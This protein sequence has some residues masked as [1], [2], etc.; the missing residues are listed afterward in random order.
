MEQEY[1]NQ[2]AII[3]WITENLG[4]EVMVPVSGKRVANGFDIY[5]QSFLLPESAIEKEMINDTYNAH[6]L[7]PGVNSYGNWENGDYAYLRYGNYDEFEPLVINRE[8]YGVVPDSTEIAEEFRLL[9]NLFYDETKK[10]YIDPADGACITVVKMNDAGFITVHKRYLKTYL[11]LKEKVI[12]IHV[13]SRCTDLDNSI[14]F[15]YSQT[16]VKAEDNSY[17]YSLTLGQTDALTRRENF[18]MVYAKKM[19]CGC[20]LSSCNIWP[21]NEAKNFIDFIIGVDDDGNELSFTC[22]PDK[23]SSYFGTNPDAPH[24]LTPVFFAPAVLEK[25]L[26]NPELYTVTDTMLSCGNLWAL[27]IDRNDAGYVSVYLGDLGRDLPSESEQHYWRGYNIITDSSISSARFKRDFMCIAASSDSED[28]VF[29]RNY[30]R[31]NSLAEEKLGWPLFL[32]LED[33]DRYNFDGLRI[34]IHNAIPEFD[35]LVLSLVKTLI[36]SLNEKN[37]VRVLTGDYTE[38]KGSIARIETWFKEKNVPNYEDHIKFLRNLQE[39]RS[40]G[41]GH[42]KGKGYKKITVALGISENNYVEAFKQLLE[43]ASAFLCF[44]ENNIELLAK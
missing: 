42:R 38:L 23:L 13:D 43:K 39:L 37:I 8:Y 10:E 28:S 34:P 7:S 31:V 4:S 20:K 21:F 29:K 19:I 1:I 3:S 32:Q 15:D 5:I 27:Y 30:V 44:V 25:Y 40:C 2:K 18:S 14:S 41:T 26:A 17:L 24:Y 22:N 11:T 9:F 16:T 36:D 33:Q 12:L 6:S 35:M